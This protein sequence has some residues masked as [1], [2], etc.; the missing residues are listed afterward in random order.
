MNLADDLY[1][2]KSYRLFDIS[3]NPG[4]KFFMRNSVTLM[5]KKQ[6][7]IIR[8]LILSQNRRNFEFSFKK[9]EHSIEFCVAFK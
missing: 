8:V 5:K 2:I 6:R 9:S 1:R 3:A 4:A 7:K